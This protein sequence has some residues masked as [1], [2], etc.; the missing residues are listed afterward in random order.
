MPQDVCHLSPCDMCCW[1]CCR[2]LRGTCHARRYAAPLQAAAVRSNGT[3]GMRTLAMASVEL[4]ARQ[5]TPLKAA[6]SAISRL[7]MLHSKSA[8]RHTNTPSAEMPLA[9]QACA[10]YTANQVCW[11]GTQHHTCIHMLPQP[12][13]VSLR[14]CRTGAQQPSLLCFHSLTIRRHINHHEVPNTI[15]ITHPC[16]QK[17]GRTTTPTTKTVVVRHICSTNFTRLLET[18]HTSHA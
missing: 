14:Y 9:K 5:T 7:R 1:S 16:Q 18:V 17:T 12:H 8:L 15:K 10:V 3:G 2:Y 13:H 11:H 6:R 4:M